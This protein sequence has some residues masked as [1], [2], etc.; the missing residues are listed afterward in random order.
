[1]GIL[2]KTFIKVAVGASAIAALSF[3]PAA[4]FAVSGATLPAGNTIYQANYSENPSA[5]WSTAA[6]GTATVI[7][8]P[9]TT[10]IGSTTDGAYNIAT[11]KSYVVC[12]G[13]DGPCT[14]WEADVTTGQ[15]TRIARIT[16][17]AGDTYNCDAFD[18]APDGTAWITMYREDAPTNTGTLAQ[19]D[20]TDGTTSNA[21]SITGMRDGISWIAIHPTSGVVYA[22]DFRQNTFTLNAATGALSLISL[23]T[24]LGLGKGYNIYDAAFDSAG[25]L[26]LTAWDDDTELFSA[27][28]TDFAATFSSQGMIQIEGSGSNT[29]TDSLWI[30]RSGVTPAPELAST[31][32]DVAAPLALG[33]GILG[34]GLTAFS[35]RRARRA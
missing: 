27:D 21:V 26:W 2:V 9:A 1:M 10:G 14:L 29:G 30:A 32:V 22:G 4:A 34:L 24:D 17:D 28:V 11:G 5:L 18:I 20:L 35:I 19:L 16:G 8:T 33:F 25:I 7:G 23:G 3:G 13:Y 6:D 12:K 31:G 15:F